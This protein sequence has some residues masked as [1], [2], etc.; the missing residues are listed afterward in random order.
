VFDFAQQ[1]GKGMSG[2]T[3]RLLVVGEAPDENLTKGG[4][5]RPVVAAARKEGT[6]EIEASQATRGAAE[7]R[8]GGN[9]TRLAN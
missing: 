1:E 7:K 5:A 8:K 6:R 9:K 2:R 3:C 4:A